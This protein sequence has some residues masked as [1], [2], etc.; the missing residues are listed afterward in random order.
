MDRETDMLRTSTRIVALALFAAT[1][2]T[3]YSAAPVAP[4]AESFIARD[5]KPVILAQ[6]GCSSRHKCR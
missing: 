2:T 6:T 4:R 1:L 3:N 5:A